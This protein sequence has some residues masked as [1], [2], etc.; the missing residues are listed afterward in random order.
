MSDLVLARLEATHSLLEK[1]ITELKERQAK[2]YFKTPRRPLFFRT[3]D[4]SGP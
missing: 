4:E 2:I 1:E 3:E